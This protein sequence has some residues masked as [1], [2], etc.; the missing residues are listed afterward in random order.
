MGNKHHYYVDAISL[1]QH[2]NAVTVQQGA[3]DYA[4]YINSDLNAAEKLDAVFH[5][6]FHLVHEH[7]KHRKYEKA[8][9]EARKRKNLHRGRAHNRRH[10]RSNS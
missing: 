3:D 1:P 5:E 4:V 9:R 2:V 8:E 6:A 7:F 10:G